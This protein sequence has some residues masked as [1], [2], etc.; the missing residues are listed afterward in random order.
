VKTDLGT[1]PA[2]GVKFVLSASLAPAHHLLFLSSAKGDAKGPAPRAQRTSRCNGANGI[3]HD[4]EVS[5]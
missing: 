2:K 3:T 5:P 1:L 4:L